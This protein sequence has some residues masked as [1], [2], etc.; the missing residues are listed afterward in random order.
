MRPRFVIVNAVIAAIC[1]AAS[2]LGLF[3]G[4]QALGTAEI[5]MLS[6]LGVMFLVG[7]GCAFRGRWES[8]YHIANTLPVWAMA[9]TGLGLLLVVATG[10]MA[11]PA[12]K[13]AMFRGIVF[14]ISPNIA[15]A[16][17]MAW[18][19]ELAWWSGRESI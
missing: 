8:V 15:A 14:A 6:M 9:F 13:A 18:L 16:A 12:D 2:R 11:T 4:V 10:S 5:A 1:V 19:R 3:G 17:F 7:I